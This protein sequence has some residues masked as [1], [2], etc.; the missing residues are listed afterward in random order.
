MA[1]LKVYLEYKRLKNEWI[2][3]NPGSTPEQYEAAI[4]RIARECGI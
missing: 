3:K 4:K 2:A 1:I